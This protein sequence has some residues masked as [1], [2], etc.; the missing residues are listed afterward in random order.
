M[1]DLVG[2]LKSPRRNMLK[3]ILN[4]HDEIEWIL[5]AQDKGK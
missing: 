1:Q 4:K 5:L 2:K 3:F